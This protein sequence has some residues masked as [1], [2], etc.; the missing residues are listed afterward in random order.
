MKNE[1]PYKILVV[2]DEEPV[3]NAIR[4]SLR[5][6]PYEL[7]FAGTAEEGLARLDQEAIDLV[8][9]D[10]VM[11]GM[12]GLDFLKRARNLHP[13]TVRIILTGNADLEMA[14][15]AI[16]EGQIYRFLTKPWDDV[17]LR[18]SLHLAFERL[19]MQREH[20]RLVELV[21][22]QSSWIRQVERLH[23]EI[24]VVHRD[25]EGAVLLSE[26]EFHEAWSAG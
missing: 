7:S 1:T 12:N 21:R 3:R 6:E 25:E 13:E 5:K 8:I 4:R 24:A 26:E 14:L 18:V 2:D 10:H 23:P 22:R 20:A 15:R 19:E 17:D 16:N 9:S 11:P